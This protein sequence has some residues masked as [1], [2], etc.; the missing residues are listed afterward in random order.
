[1]CRNLSYIELH[2]RYSQ[3]YVPSDF[4]RC[5]MLWKSSFSLE[6]P[7]TFASTGLDFHVLSKDIDYP[8]DDLPSEQPEDADARYF[9]KVLLLS[10]GGAPTLRQKLTGLLVDGTIDEACEVQSIFKLLQ[11]VVG[12]QDC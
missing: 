11:A 4:I 6:T 9:V 3:L 5:E 1:M 7:I 10:H 2:K 8:T 12:R